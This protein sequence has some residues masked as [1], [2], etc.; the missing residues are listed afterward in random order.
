MMYVH[1]E[2]FTNYIDI[3][4]R[5]RATPSNPANV[6][7]ITKCI[8]SCSRLIEKLMKIDEYYAQANRTHH[9]VFEHILLLAA[10]WVPDVKGVFHDDE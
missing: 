5:Y 7:E 1:S 2:K 8:A 9:S 4:P 6:S 10:S 3:E